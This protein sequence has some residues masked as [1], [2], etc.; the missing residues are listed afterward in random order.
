MHKLAFPAPALPALGSAAEPAASARACAV[1]R[2]PLHGGRALRCAQCA[3]GPFHPGCALP[4]S[5]S[6]PRCPR[7]AQLVAARG[8]GAA[9]ARVAGPREQVDLTGVPGAGVVGA[10]AAG[11]SRGRG[12]GDARGRCRHGKQWGK[13]RKCRGAGEGAGGGWGGEGK[14]GKGRGAEAAE[15]VR[16][17]P[18]QKAQCPDC[19]GGS[20][21]A[22]WRRRSLCKDCGGTG[23]CQQNRIW[24]ICKD[25][26]GTS[27]CQH[28]RRRSNC[29][30]CGGSG[31]CPHN[32]QRRTHNRLRER[33]RRTGSA[34]GCS[35]ALTHC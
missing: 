2:E 8:A 21:C 28:N 19:G 30:D 13:C 4:I 1:C 6:Q 20:I 9:V 7:C 26:G 10:G 18:L 14:E 15:E 34:T 33:R 35:F 16:A 29:K 25:C 27:I 24:S 23:I 3:C 17:R 5:G 12:G 11:G 32:R 22:H 31:I